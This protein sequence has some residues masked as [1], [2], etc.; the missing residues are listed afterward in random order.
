MEQAI[1]TFE[2]GWL[3]GVHQGPPPAPGSL[4]PTL[5]AYW[6]DGYHAAL[7]EMLQ[8]SGARPLNH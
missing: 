4:D 2:E 3:C 7:E 1:A 6:N 5:E 8:E